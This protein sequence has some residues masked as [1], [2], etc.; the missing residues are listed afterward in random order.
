MLWDVF[1]TVW[2]VFLRA[3]SGCL[4]CQNQSSIPGVMVQMKFVTLPMCYLSLP[5]CKT[6]E[7]VHQ[8]MK[9][10][11][12][13]SLYHHLLSCIQK[14]RLIVH[15]IGVLPILCFFSLLSLLSVQ[16]LLITIMLLMVLMSIQFVVVPDPWFVW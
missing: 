10:L 9:P 13:Y 1:G 16:T 4:D 2:K 11:W 14:L 8:L 15:E 6:L 3:F 7:Y 5:P 12:K